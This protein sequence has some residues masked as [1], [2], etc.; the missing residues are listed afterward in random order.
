M[1]VD[2]LVWE[3][4]CRG[5]VGDSHFVRKELV[6]RYSRQPG[7]DLLSYIIANTTGRAHQ[8]ANLGLC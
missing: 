2:L 7:P 1:F 6:V 3:N 5:R 4:V 8:G